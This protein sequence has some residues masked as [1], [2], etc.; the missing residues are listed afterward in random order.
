MSV[1]PS[2]AE[3][4]SDLSARADEIDA[5]RR[6][7][8]D[9]VEELRASGLLHLWLSS[10]LGGAEVD[11]A[12]GLRAFEDLARANASTSWCVMLPNA[13][14][15]ASAVIRQ[16]AAEEVHARSGVVLGGSIN[17]AEATATRVKGGY[18]LT[19]RWA[20]VSGSPYC[21]WF[22]LA[23]LC[24]HGVLFSYVPATSVD[25]ED[26]WHAL[27]LRG[28][29]SNHVSVRDVVVPE[30]FTI[31]PAT[32]EPWVSGCL[33]R[34]PAMHVLACAIP[35]VALGI[36]RRALD[37]LVVLASMKTPFAS[38]RPLAARHVIQSEL[39]RAEAG[40]RGARANFYDEIEA[41]WTEV[42][43]QGHASIDQR[44]RVR[45]A[46]T[47]A[48]HAAAAAVDFA[49]AAGGGNSVYDTSPLQRC[50]RDVH[51]VTQH[52]GAS[53]ANFQVAGRLLLGLGTDA[54]F[55]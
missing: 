12:T 5:G 10:R 2:T 15:V 48:V 51:A 26:T 33:Y 36:G 20:F 24:D 41:E 19:G 22:V 31:D 27:G 55:L 6:L 35:P 18:R 1:L 43:D 25:V 28:T 39:A 7:P 38:A 8:P 46:V 42:V 44:G 49:Y 34:V 52:V 16:E 37:E 47:N 17:P 3:L 21:D 30:A 13:T 53:A 50:F 11:L 32:A 29:A 23:A 45:L 4:A 40:L 14:A 54:T 9:L